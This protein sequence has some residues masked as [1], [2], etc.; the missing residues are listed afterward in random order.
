MTGRK[1]STTENLKD[2][3]SGFFGN[4]ERKKMRRHVQ[5]ILGP[6][7]TGKTTTLINIVEQSLKRGVP[8]ERI[9]YLAFTRKAATEAQERAMAQFGFD[10]DRFAA[11]FPQGVD[12]SRVRQKYRSDAGQDPLKEV[13]RA[14]PGTTEYS[15]YLSEV[16]DELKHIKSGYDSRKKAS[17]R[18]RK[19]ASKIQDA[20]TEIR[21]LKRKND[22]VLEKEKLLMSDPKNKFD[23]DA[24]KEWFSKDKK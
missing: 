23:R 19:E 2:I 20:Y 14:D 3:T 7:G 24:I 16:M 5:I 6:P 22:R 18:Y 11:A 21:R 9:A 10:A 8:P 15:T 12:P 17:A 13:K 1:V 4:L